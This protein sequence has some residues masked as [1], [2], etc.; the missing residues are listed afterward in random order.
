MLMSL[1]PETT[2]EYTLMLA[3][4]ITDV[5]DSELT[6]IQHHCLAAASQE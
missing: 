1:H 6:V 4:Q 2:G 3:M 5:A